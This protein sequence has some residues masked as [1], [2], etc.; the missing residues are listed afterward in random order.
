LGRRRPNAGIRL[1]D[2]LI[3][4]NLPATNSLLEGVMC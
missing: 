3:A 1:N 4:G 2:G